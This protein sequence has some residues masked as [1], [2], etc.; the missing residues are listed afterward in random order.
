M[1]GKAIPVVDWPALDL[2]LGAAEQGAQNIREALGGLT[3]DEVRRV[4]TDAGIDPVQGAAAASLAVDLAGVLLDLARAM[5]HAAPALARALGQDPEQENAICP[6]CGGPVPVCEVGTVACH[7]ECGYCSHPAMNGD[8]CALCDAERGTLLWADR[9][10]LKPGDGGRILME[11]TEALCEEFLAK[12]GSRE[13]PR[14]GQDGG[15]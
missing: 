6:R 4:A 2:V 14:G 7:R 1:E 9:R 11:K 8:F 3:V 12:G 15:D 5:R 13:P 10:S